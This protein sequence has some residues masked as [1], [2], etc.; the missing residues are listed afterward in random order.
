M[1]RGGGSGVC[2]YMCAA[3]WLEEGCTVGARRRVTYGAAAVRIGGSGQAIASN[4]DGTVL[5]GRDAGQQLW[6][7]G[8]WG[9]QAGCGGDGGGAGVGEDK[10]RLMKGGHLGRRM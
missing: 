5:R 3:G 9:G 2:P 10:G 8:L 1:W 4:E 7:L 6:T